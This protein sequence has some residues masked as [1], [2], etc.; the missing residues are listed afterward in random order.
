MTSKTV[1]CVADEESLLE[2]RRK[3]LESSGFSVLTSSNKTDAVATFAS[4]P[5]DAIVVESSAPDK[6]SVSVP[7]PIKRLRP[8]TPVILLSANPPTAETTIT[9]V[10][11]FIQK[12]QEPELLASRLESLIALRS[13]SHPELEQEYVI[14]ADASRRYL[15][16]S[17]GV[18]ELLGY[19]RMDLIGMTIEDVSYVPER[20]PGLFEKFVKHGEQEGEYIL[21]HK[22]GKPVLIRYRSYIFSDGC[23]AAVWEPILGWK[24]LYSAAL[25]ELDPIRLK[26]RVQ[27]AQIAIEARI[28]ELTGNI[29]SEPGE[30]QALQDA[31]SGLKILSREFTE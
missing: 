26:E 8:K 4:Q 29:Q 10:D 7:A 23:I 21:R 17:D 28:L 30:W 25:V 20:V 24:Q 6:N 5:V 12:E 22:T 3:I 13:H 16:C 27:A 19:P 2:R 1:L 31:A 14:F 18:C 9:E 15:D 11:A